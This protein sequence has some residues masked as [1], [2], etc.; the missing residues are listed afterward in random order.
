MVLSN[1]FVCAL[2]VGIATTVSAQSYGYYAPFVTPGNW[3]T[4]AGNEVCGTG[5]LQSPIDIDDSYSYYNAY[6]YT[7]KIAII[8]DKSAGVEQWTAANNNFKINMAPNNKVFSFTTFGITYNLTTFDFHWRGSETTIN[9][10]VFGGELHFQFTGSNGRIA[11]VTKF[12]EFSNNDNPELQKIIDQAITPT[13]GNIQANTATQTVTFTL[14]NF[15][16]YT[17]SQYYYFNGSATQPPCTENVDWFVVAQDN[18][19]MSEKQA[20]QLQLIQGSNNLNVV[21]NIRPV[22]PTNYRTIYKS[23]SQSIFQIPDTYA[24]FRYDSS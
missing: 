21:G 5:Q 19:L 4:I 10:R 12:V 24:P 7:I 16:P 8:A 2:L 18:I 23:F 6:L 13:T 15:L 22:Q 3:A 11:Y 14:K 17:F 9:K 1:V 20:S